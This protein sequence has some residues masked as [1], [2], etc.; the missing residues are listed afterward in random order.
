METKEIF[1]KQI[2]IISILKSLIKKSEK[3][4][5]FI[6][7]KEFYYSSWSHCLGYL[8]I[9]ELLYQTSLIFKIKIFFSNIYLQ[10]LFSD[11]QKIQIKK[12]KK[13]NFNKIVLSW[14][15]K[16]DF[17]KDTYYDRYFSSNS[18]SEN[19]TLWLLIS[20]DGYFTDHI[21]NVI[22]FKRK[23][24]F[25]NF[26]RFIIISFFNSLFKFNLNNFFILEN[27][28]IK[29]E[30]TI[31]KIL[32]IIKVKK[33]ILPY[34]GQIFQNFILSS[35]NKKTAV[36][37][38]GYIH[39][40][41]PPLPSEYIKRQGSPKK[42]IVHGNLQ[43]KIL[44]KNLGWSRKEIF[45]KRSARYKYN[46]KKYFKNK[47]F[48]PM[49]F[50]DKN[51]LLIYLENFLKKQKKN[52]LHPFKIKNHPLMSN[53]QNHLRFIQNIN[54]LFK[55]YYFKFD[56]KNKNKES[57]SIFFSA[58]ASI[59]ETLEYGIDVIHIVNDPIMEVHN[60]IIWKFI[61]TKKID[62][63][64]YSYQLKKKKSYI[65]FQDKNFKFSRWIK[66]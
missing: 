4:K 15:Y 20:M 25:I 30:K 14:C 32:R 22:I 16:N 33:F 54:Q 66:L 24:S 1:S 56:K 2:E 42:I 64:I 13:K 19:D 12:L 37:T 11:L 5:N 27:F 53:S 45:L 6:L 38:I 61:E 7:L 23:V 29:I 55:K 60:P 34:E 65:R 35:V 9:K 10:F 59:I 18:K 21:D 28:Y 58:T 26:I 3:K 52:S 47:I 17:N 50:E 31:S 46:N 40:A 51:L 57:K 44:L 39:S 36:E 41:L 48:L 8:K 43:K 49:T 63:N 62:E